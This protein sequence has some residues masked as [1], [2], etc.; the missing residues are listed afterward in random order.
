[1]P[2][3]S[4][5]RQKWVSDRR[6]ADAEKLVESIGTGCQVAART[7]GYMTMVGGGIREIARG[8]RASADTDVFPTKLV[9]TLRLDY[10]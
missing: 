4:L 2:R 1:V 7:G 10:G 8:T 6:F 3:T 9:F 5:E